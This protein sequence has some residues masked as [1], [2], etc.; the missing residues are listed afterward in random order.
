MPRA[1]GRS[2]LQCENVAMRQLE[3][4]RGGIRVRGAVVLGSRKENSR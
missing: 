3:G 1:G 2:C 4:E